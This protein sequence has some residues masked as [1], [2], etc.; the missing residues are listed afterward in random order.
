MTTSGFQLVFTP[1]PPL[2][3]EVGEV[4]DEVAPPPPVSSRPRA[5]PTTTRADYRHAGLLSEYGGVKGWLAAD[6][7]SR[8]R[9]RDSL[10]P[11]AQ[12]E[13]RRRNL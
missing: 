2:P 9:S 8:K 3:H 5:L 11:E 7:W 10:A 13:T 6:S 12:G 4:D 1:L